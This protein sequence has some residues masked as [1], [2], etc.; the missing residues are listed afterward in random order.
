MRT[1]LLTLSLATLAAC[2]PTIPDSGAGV[3]FTGIGNEPSGNAV[4]TGGPASGVPSTPGATPVATTGSVGISDEQD[5][6]AV[7]ERESI[8]SDA[9][10][11]AANRA[12]YEV[13]AVRDLP[14]RPGNGLSV[15]VEYALATNNPVGQPLYRR[16]GAFAESRFTRNCAKYTS[17]DAAQE[18]FLRRG[19]PE[20]DSKG[21]DPDGD[22]FACY[23]SPEPFRQARLAAQVPD[24]MPEPAAAPAE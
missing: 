10:R 20:R 24:P 2:A 9:A 19:G 4:A 16:S 22:G 21:L 3:G 18:D 13:V 11:I 12:R 23:W 6:S 7:S 5:F 17:P 8:E 1:L 14:V 15:V